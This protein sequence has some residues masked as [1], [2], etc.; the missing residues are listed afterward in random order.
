M[1]PS[2]HRRELVTGSNPG[3]PATAHGE[4]GRSERGVRGRRREIDLL[5]GRLGDLARGRGSIVVIR[6]AVGLGKT[7]LLDHLARLAQNQGIR[8]FRGSGELTAQTVPLGP[9]L[10]ALV[11]HEDPPIDLQVLRSL[12][13]SSDQRCSSLSSLRRT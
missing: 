3:S 2:D 5:A 7:T 8:V 11:V 6:G 9:L 1:A 12:S 10:Q 13:A 4:P